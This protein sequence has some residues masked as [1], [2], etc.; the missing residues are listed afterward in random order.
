MQ[1]EAFEKIEHEKGLIT[2][3]L[4]KRN[5]MFETRGFDHVKDQVI[6]FLLRADNKALRAFLDSPKFRY[7]VYSNAAK[8]FFRKP[9]SRKEEFSTDENGRFFSTPLVAASTLDADVRATDRMAYHADLLTEFER[10]VEASHI[11]LKDQKII[12][13]ILQVAKLVV[14][15]WKIGEAAREYDVT[16]QEASRRYVLIKERYPD[17]FGA[18]PHTLSEFRRGSKF[19]GGTGK[20]NESEYAREINEQRRQDA[21]AGLRVLLN[22]LEQPGSDDKLNNLVQIGGKDLLIK[23]IRYHLEEISRNELEASATSHV[24]RRIREGLVKE[25]GLHNLPFRISD[26]ERERKTFLSL[27]ELREAVKEQGVTTVNGYVEESSKHVDWPSYPARIYKD[28]WKG[29]MD[30]FGKE[31]VEYI[32]FQQLKNEVG[33]AKVKNNREYAEIKKNHPDWP[34]HPANIYGKQWPG[35]RKFLETAFPTFDELQMAVRARGVRNIIEYRKLYKQR[36][37]PSNPEVVYE[38]KWE[39]WPSFLGNK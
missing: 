23:V 3:L 2:S 34:S 1:T 10:K 8:G 22:E 6:D 26:V 37:W 17:I 36:G 16:G 9:D 35:W 28:E 12:K 7:I 13:D 32:P 39:G 5:K 4:G 25:L 21:M 33:A 11:P 27:Q 19:W 18:L 20:S 30:F 14:A 24:L 38:E 31:K 15:G 29:W